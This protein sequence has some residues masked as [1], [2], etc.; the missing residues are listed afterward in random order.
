MKI[1]NKLFAT[2]IAFAAIGT[3]AFADEAK[4]EAYAHPTLFG[5]QSQ[6]L[7]DGDSTYQMGGQIL[8]TKRKT[9]D[10]SRIIRIR[11]F[12]FLLQ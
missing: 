1:V 4:V 8:K 7:V 6:T 5:T 11:C 12:Q 2:T 3:A 9:A 10:F